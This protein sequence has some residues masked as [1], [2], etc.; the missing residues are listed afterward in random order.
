M[1]NYA[2]IDSSGNVVNVVDLEEGAEWSPPE[3]HTSVQSDIASIGWTY[4][5]GTFTAPQT[6]TP[7]PLPVFLAS[8]QAALTA[9]DDTMKR[10][11]EAI[12]LGTNSATS[13]DVVAFVQYRRSLRALLSSTT[14][15]TIPAK[16]AYP[17]GT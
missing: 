9:S 17:A 2:I 16:P 14:V 6:P 11:Q 7:N 3:G 13:P 8:V 10:V 5:N 15:T 4:V 12:T 1:S